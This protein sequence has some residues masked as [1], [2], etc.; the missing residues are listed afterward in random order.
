[1]VSTDISRTP[2]GKL[3]VNQET[4]AKE[5]REQ[6]YELLGRNIAREICYFSPEV[7]GFR[8]VL[9]AFPVGSIWHIRRG[10]KN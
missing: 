10:D 7:I 9:D 5:Q 1:M 8:R 4:F 3:V 6:N 2:D